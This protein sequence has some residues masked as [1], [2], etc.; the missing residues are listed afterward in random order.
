MIAATQAFQ[1][2]L[3]AMRAA[4]YGQARQ[5][6]PMNV[7]D[8]WNGNA[9]EYMPYTEMRKNPG[10]YLP[11]GEADKALAKENLMQDIMGTSQLTRSAINNLQEDF[12]EDMKAKIALAMR[13]DDPHS[14]LDMLIS[15]GS[16]GAL[17]SDQQDF[18]IATRQLAENAMAMRTI[19]GAG[20]GS[21]D[22][23]NAIRDTLP[24]LLTPDR[25]F[26][27]RQLDAFDKTI[28]RLHRGVPKV[29][30]RTDI[31]NGGGAGGA[32]GGGK[33]K[34]SLSKAMKLPFNKGKTEAQVRA[35]LEAHNYEVIP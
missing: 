28:A 35:D 4:G 15:S 26:A 5:M 16:L 12:P 3:A 14:A 10:R 17:S 9:P 33:P 27:L 7:L 18:L 2:K 34:H 25:S 21:E 20:Q 32:G 24:G 31:E 29:P 13:A 19:L 8:T 11:A 23:R 22:M 30:L 6:A 1:E